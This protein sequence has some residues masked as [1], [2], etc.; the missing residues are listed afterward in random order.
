MKL[1]L[2]EKALS[3]NVN[4]KTEKKG[5]LTYLSWA[6][7]WQEFKKIYPDGKY[8]IKLFD[9]LPY[10]KSDAGV[11]VYTTVTAVEESHTMWLPVMDYKNQAI[12]NPDMMQINKTIMRCLTKNLAMFGIGLYIYAG[13]D[14]PNADDDK[15][16]DAQPAKQEQQ[17]TPPKDVKLTH[18][19]VDT[20]ELFYLKKTSLSQEKIEK[21][22]KVLQSGSNA[23]LNGLHAYL[24][25]L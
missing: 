20:Q 11:M 16:S 5:N 24:T 9:G 4:H 3:L 7:A 2:F 15:K 23:E 22:E 17:P 10:I 1:E 18:P 8:E 13:E 6:F 21:A 25:S 14:L 12:K 19:K